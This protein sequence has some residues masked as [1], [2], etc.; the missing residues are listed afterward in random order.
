M[1]GVGRTRDDVLI[2]VSAS[3]LINFFLAHL[4]SVFLKQRRGKDLSRRLNVSNGAQTR[5]DPR[6]GLHTRVPKS[7]VGPLWSSERL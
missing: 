1:R 7:Q 4:Q 5:V 2:A 6:H 3:V